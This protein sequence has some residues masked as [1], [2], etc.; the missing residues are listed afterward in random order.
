VGASK[1]SKTNQDDIA[2][3][4][5]FL[6][7]DRVREPLAKKLNPL[8]WFMNDFEP[9]P[10]GWYRPGKPLRLLFWYFRNPFQN[11]GRY[12]IGVADHSY[13]VTGEWPVVQTVWE[14]VPWVDFPTLTPRHGLKRATITL[15]NGRTLPWLSYS[16]PRWLVYWGWQPNG[17]AGV[18]FNRLAY[19]LSPVLP[20][21]LLGLVLVR[22]WSLI[23]ATWG[24]RG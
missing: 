15:E 1:Q 11:A 21:A 6:V 23:P 24:M 4:E 16:T 8:W 2:L 17:F 22:M 9:T 10:P 5:T 19:L 14:D 12:V 20:L 7:A 18:K 13:T 3:I